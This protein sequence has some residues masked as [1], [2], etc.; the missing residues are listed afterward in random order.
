MVNIRKKWL[1]KFFLQKKEHFY[2]LWNLYRI[3]IQ[4]KNISAGDFLFLNKTQI[5]KI[6]PGSFAKFLQH[7]NALENLGF[8]CGTALKIGGPG[9]KKTA[10]AIKL[11]PKT[12]V[13]I[14]E[15]LNDKKQ[16][17]EEY[18]RIQEEIQDFSC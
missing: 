3:E 5:K 11:L 12:Y 18:N 13:I 9:K 4:R 17:L 7:I 2:I 10:C 15:F 6:F 14:Q 16:I 1:Q 8:I